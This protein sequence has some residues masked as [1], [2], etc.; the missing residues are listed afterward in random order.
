MPPHI[1]NINSL[2]SP[3]NDND[4]YDYT[5]LVLKN[6]DFFIEKYF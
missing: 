3:L 6:K 5:E 4:N 1:I 2:F